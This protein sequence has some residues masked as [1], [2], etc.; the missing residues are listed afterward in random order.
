VAQSLALGAGEPVV[1]DAGNA[2]AGAPAD[3]AINPR[4]SGRP[5]GEVY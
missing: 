3:E 5:A 4:G 1:P 2:K